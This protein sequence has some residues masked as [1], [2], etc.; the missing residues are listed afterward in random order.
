MLP[1]VHVY[2]NIMYVH[3]E[4][5]LQFWMNCCLGSKHKTKLYSHVNPKYGIYYFWD[6]SSCM[7]PHGNFVLGSYFGMFLVTYLTSVFSHYL[8]C[9]YFVYIGDHCEP[10]EYHQRVLQHSGQSH[11]C[12][13]CQDT[14]S[15]TQ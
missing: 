2:V 9:M 8:S 14:D 13:Q 5:K 7:E 4:S 10:S 12:N 11:H 1:S 15:L 3:V 6:Q